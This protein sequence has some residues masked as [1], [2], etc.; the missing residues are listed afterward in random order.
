MED[1]EWMDKVD[2]E[3]IT[4]IAGGDTMTWDNYSLEY[5]EEGGHNLWSLTLKDTET[6]EI[7]WDTNNFE[8]IN[9]LFEDGFLDWKKPQE[10]IEYLLAN[11][12][13][14]KPGPR[15]LPESFGTRSVSIDK[16][17]E[18]YSYNYGYLKSSIQNAIKDLDS[19]LSHEP[20][21]DLSLLAQLKDRLEKDLQKAEGSVDK[22]LQDFSHQE[23][24]ETEGLF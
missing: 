16:K 13:I 11:K 5:Y 17:S 1:T 7:L 2:L 8:E 12:G 20:R 23:H 15:K 14:Q 24:T 21:T 4:K 10:S 22:D 18:S 6:D 9:E 3:N 19:F